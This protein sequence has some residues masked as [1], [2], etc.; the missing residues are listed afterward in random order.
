MS[1]PDTPRPI[2]SPRNR[3]QFLRETLAGSALLSM[4]GGVPGFLRAAVASP[5]APADP[6]KRERV[7]VVV[8]LSG[9]NDGL[10]T[11]VPFKDDLYYKK[12]PSL[13]V[14]P[15]Q[16]HQLTDRL[17]LNPA[18]A[19]MGRLYQ[20]KRLTVVEGVGYADSSRSHFVSMD[21]W[22]SA[23]PEKPDKSSGWLGRGLAASGI[24]KTGRI[25]AIALGGKELPPALVGDGVS[26]PAVENLAEFQIRLEGGSDADRSA[27]KKL[28][29][30]FAASPT[31]SGGGA[32][33]DLAFVSSTMATTFAASE[34][35]A[36][37]TASAKD[38]VKYPDGPLARSLRQAAQVIAAG[39]PT[40]VFYC[41]LGGFDTHAKQVAIQTDL[42][43]QVSESVAAFTDDVAAQ[44]RDKDVLLMTFSEFGRRVEANASHG[45][46]HGTAGP[47][48]FA[49]GGVAGGVVGN[50]PDLSDLLDGG[51]LK[52]QFDFRRVYATVLD[53]WLGID[54]AKVLGGRFEGLPILG[55]E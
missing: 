36:E 55:R 14:D 11:V 10:N 2:I 32:G 22:H 46:D 6:S 13:A 26:V 15:R 43:R 25:P 31:L 27:R 54:S 8:Q 1:R 28:M 37:V 44:G 12:R 35:L 41:S 47:M 23:R 51:D 5:A 48:F 30:E 29:S 33:G 42:L 21:V 19:A 45:T 50:P 18:M 24:A 39:F 52:H 17:G 53:R 20:Q 40:R 34:A 7:L 49:G 3:R 38:R 4:T 9:G 16:V